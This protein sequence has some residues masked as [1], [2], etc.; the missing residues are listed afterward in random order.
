MIKDR[1][2]KKAPS[3]PVLESSYKKGKFPKDD[4]LLVSK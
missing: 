3:N 1:V 4:S 2:P